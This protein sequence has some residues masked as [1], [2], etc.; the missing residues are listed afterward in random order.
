MSSEARRATPS[1]CALFGHRVDRHDADAAGNHQQAR[2][3]PVDAEGRVRALDLNGIADAQRIYGPGAGIFT[4]GD[5]PASILLAVETAAQRCLSERRQ[6][7]GGL[8]ASSSP[9]DPA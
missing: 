4:Y 1:A 5:A 2:L 3:A 9:E 6:G 7:C 8:A